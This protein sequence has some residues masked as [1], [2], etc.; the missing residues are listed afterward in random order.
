MEPES[1][2]P[3]NSNEFQSDANQDSSLAL[4]S[5]KEVYCCPYSS[6]NFSTAWKSSLNM[7][8]K[9]HTGKY[10]FSFLFWYAIKTKISLCALKILK[11]VI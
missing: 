11:Y 1:K 9:T 6:C 8:M 5:V 2:L 7:H 3:T 4:S 10:K